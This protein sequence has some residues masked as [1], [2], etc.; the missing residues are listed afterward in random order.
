MSLFLRILISHVCILSSRFVI[1]EP[2]ADL[3][4]STAAIDP[5]LPVPLK[6]LRQ[7]SLL[8]ILR[9]NRGYASIAHHQVIV[10]SHGRGLVSIA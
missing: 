10:N 6:L 2:M 1:L 7:L 9:L 3:S 4:S 8:A 5:R